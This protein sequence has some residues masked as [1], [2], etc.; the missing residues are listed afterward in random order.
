MTIVVPLYDE[1][2]GVPALADALRQ[3]RKTSGGESPGRPER[4]IDLVL[5]D[6][7]SHDGTW[8]ALGEQFGNDPG[9]ELIR[10]PPNRGLCAALRT[11]G[12]AATG[13]YIGWLY[14][15]LTY[16]PEILL[17]LAGQLDDGAAIACA[18]C[19][20]P[21]GTVLGV[22]G[23]RRVLSGVASTVWRIFTRSGQ[24]TYTCMVRVWRREA[25]EFCQPR[26]AGFLGV[27]ESLLRALRRGYRV[28]E[29]P[30]V[31][32]R[33]R[34]GQSKMRVLRVGLGQLVLMVRWV[35]RRI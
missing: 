22:P 11:G 20:H 26:Y 7:G 8:E 10:H 23:W 21:D 2:A 30:A 27:T 25:L 6:D 32:S 33:R 35:L 4:S 24:H 29:T 18:S 5:V 3:V 17:A 34:V 28:A 31:L 16:D 14:A 13:A 9:V 12:A 19:Y 1:R 15:D